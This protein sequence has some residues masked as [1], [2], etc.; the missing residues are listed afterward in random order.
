MSSDIHQF[1]LSFPGLSAQISTARQGAG[2]LHITDEELVGRIAH[3]LRM[4]VG[5]SL[6]LFDGQRSVTSEIAQISPIR[7]SNVR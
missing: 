2:E 4:E 7:K 1:A 5:Q 3:V 6:V